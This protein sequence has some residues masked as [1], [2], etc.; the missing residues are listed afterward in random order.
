[1]A[2]VILAA[3]GTGGH[4]FPALAVGELLSA[5]GHQVMLL[6]DKRGAPMVDGKISYQVISSASPFTKGIFKKLTGILRLELGFLQS[7]WVMTRQRPQSVIGFGGYPSLAPI[8]AGRLFRARCILHEQN[9]VMGR[10][11]RLLARLA[12][13][14]A[15]SFA[16]T[17]GCPS[18]VTATHTGLPVRR[19]F[20]EIS[21]YEPAPDSCHL[22]IIGGSL[23]AGIFAEILP[24]AIALLPDAQKARLRITQQARDEDIVRLQAAYKSHDITAEIARFYDD[25]PSLY[26]SADIIISR[27]GASS[28]GEISAAGRAS[29]LIPFAGA[30]D[31]HQTGNAQILSTCAAAIMISEQQASPSLLAESLQEL[32]DQPHKRVQMSQAAASQA[33]KDTAFAIASLT[34]LSLPSSG[35]AS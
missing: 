14:V 5:S 18:D 22:V 2:N 28:I 34:G 27:A 7:L 31:D 11:N 30:L 26:E 16:K 20:A 10:A 6:T 12:H 33:P 17:K 3:G 4:I 23:G 1:M 25:I 19:A 21:G 32:I 13:H 35:A 24:E 9:A 15:L 8:V 29:I